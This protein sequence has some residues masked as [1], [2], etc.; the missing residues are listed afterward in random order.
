MLF[1]VMYCSIC[2]YFWHLLCLDL[3]LY[4]SFSF[5]TP[6]TGNVDSLDNHSAIAI[7]KNVPDT[8]ANKKNC[9][10]AIIWQPKKMYMN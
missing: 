10:N 7:C 1:E 5:S 4:S 2:F 8:K 3:K 6:C 9:E